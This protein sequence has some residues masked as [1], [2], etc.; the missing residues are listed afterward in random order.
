MTVGVGCAKWTE[1]AECGEGIERI[2]RVRRD[3]LNCGLMGVGVWWK[4]RKK[5][6]F[7]DGRRIEKPAGG[8]SVVWFWR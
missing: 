7:E 2:L 8:Q 5:E 6:R 1:W 3:V 4:L